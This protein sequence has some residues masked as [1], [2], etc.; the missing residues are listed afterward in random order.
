VPDEVMM[1]LR[2]TIEETMMMIKIQARRV[3]FQV[4]RVMI[5]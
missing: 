3:S 4:R 1:V 5:Y 2:I